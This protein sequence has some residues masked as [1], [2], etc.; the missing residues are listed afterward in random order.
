MFVRKR[1]SRG[2]EH[3]TLRAFLAL[4]FA[5]ESE[6]ET[7]WL[8]P[9]HKPKVCPALVSLVRLLCCYGAS[10]GESDCETMVCFILQEKI[11][12][13]DVGIVLMT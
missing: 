5:F 11:S 12:N 13:E 7:V 6:E 3:L 4:A 1:D 2:L 10:D 8:R 9:N